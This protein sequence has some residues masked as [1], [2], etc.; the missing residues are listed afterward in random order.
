MRLATAHPP[1]LRQAAPLPREAR[2]L[3]RSRQRSHESTRLSWWCGQEAVSRLEDTRMS[4][5]SR[6][7]RAAKA[8]ARTGGKYTAAIRANR[9]D[10]PAPPGLGNPVIHSQLRRQNQARHQLLP[11]RNRRAL[12]LRSGRTRRQRVAMERVGSRGG[13][14]WQLPTPR[15]SVGTGC[16]KWQRGHSRASVCRSGFRDRCP[17]QRRSAPATASSP[18]DA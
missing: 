4:A 13:R 17:T 7:S 6:S 15:P 1:A 14:K 18:A 10:H 3:R 2:S 11:S 5:S 9:P 12:C 16:L 8:A